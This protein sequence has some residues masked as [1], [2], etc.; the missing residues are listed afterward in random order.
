[1]SQ[2]NIFAEL[3]CIMAGLIVEQLFFGKNEVT[4]GAACDILLAT[5]WATLMVSNFGMT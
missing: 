3:D 2:K 5:Y 1:M 4:I